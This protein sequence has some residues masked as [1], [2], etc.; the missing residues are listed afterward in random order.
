MFDR[1][2][3]LPVSQSGDWDNNNDNESDNDNKRIDNDK[4]DK[5]MENRLRH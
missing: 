2:R 4:A 5:E 3:L 1:S